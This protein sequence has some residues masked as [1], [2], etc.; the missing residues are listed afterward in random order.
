[1]R[2][3]R[4]GRRSAPAFAIALLACIAGL[5]SASQYSLSLTRVHLSAAHAVE[6][7]V[8]GNQ[9]QVPLELEVQV[10]RW[11]QDAEGKWTFGPGDGLVVHPLILRVPPGGEARVRIGSLSPSVKDETAY[12]VEF[13]ELPD[14]KGPQ[15]GV[16]R[17]LTRVN[18]PVFVQPKDA[19]ARLAMA[20]DALDDKGAQLTFRNAG[21]GYA[22]PA[23]ATLT[24]RDG[25]GRA[26]HESQV[27]LGYVLAG[28]QWHLLAAVPAADCARAASIDV[29]VG[30]APPM[31]A[32]IAPGSRRCPR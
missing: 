17:M 13:R 24:V 10:Q 20:V 26:L 2:N 28:A 16:V 32:A 11:Q 23:D 31:T 9:E 25:A 7:V 8:L 1:M 18:I 30:Q 5:A 15:A 21:T 6:T 27:T 22:A 19:Q 4:L 29:R 12:R 14:R 3:F